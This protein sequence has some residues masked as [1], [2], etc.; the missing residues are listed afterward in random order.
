MLD[1]PIEPIVILSAD[2]FAELPR[3]H[4]PDRLASLARFAVAPRRG[5]R[6]PDPAPVIARL[7]SL[8]DRVDLFDGPDLDI[9]A[10][11]IRARVAAGRPIDELV[12]ADVAA[13][14]AAHELYRAP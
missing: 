11:D 4:E 9:S 10:S 6:P 14:I 12:T 13:Y 7:P 2:A 1:R 8:A 3:W 5:H